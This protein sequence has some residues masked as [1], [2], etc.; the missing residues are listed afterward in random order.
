MHA[1]QA[2][3]RSARQSGIEAHE[4]EKDSSGV[5]RPTGGVYWSLSHS[6]RYVA[7][8]V[9]PC[10]V[11]IDIEEIRNVP[12]E[13]KN[14]IASRAEWQLPAVDRQPA[15]FFRYW[16]AKEAVLKATGHGLSGLVSCR[17]TKIF[18]SD[19]IQVN[20]Q[21]ADWLV[22]QRVMRA[23]GLAGLPG[24]IAAVTSGNHKVLWQTAGISSE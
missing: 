18:D 2:L 19:R 5:P 11:G 10:A 9:A 22:H 15:L 12:D 1:R 21:G 13:L 20:Y 17:V 24:C 7:A 14:Q 16:T 23:G 8:V 4:P 3:E 6:G